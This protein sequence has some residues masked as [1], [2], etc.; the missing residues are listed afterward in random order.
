MTTRYRDQ[1][2]SSYESR[3]KLNPFLYKGRYARLVRRKSMDDLVDAVD[4]LGAK[5]G[6]GSRAGVGEGG[7]GAV[8]SSTPG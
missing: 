5:V 1:A 8:R 3:W 6:D 7:E 2:G 4:R